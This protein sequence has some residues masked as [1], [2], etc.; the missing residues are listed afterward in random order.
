MR[1]LGCG[2]RGRPAATITHRG[3]IG[4]GTDVMSTI[5]PSLQSASS[6]AAF[7][8]TAAPALGLRKRV[9]D[10]V[11]GVPIDAT[12]WQDALNRIAS[13]AARQES[14]V[15]CLCNVHSVVTATQDRRHWNAISSA[16]LA[17][18]DG[19]PIA[20]ALRRLGH[21]RQ[22][23][24]SGPDLM[25]AVCE[26]AE[27]EGQA[28]YL[29]GGTPNTL[30]RLQERLLAMY[31]ELVIAGAVSPPFRALTTNEDGGVVQALNASGASILFVG[32]GCPKQEAWMHERRNRVRAVMLGVGASFDFHAGAIR[33]APVWMQNCGLEWLHRLSCDPRRLWKRYLVTNALFAILVMKMLLAGVPATKARGSRRLDP[34]D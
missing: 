22:T 9:K 29:Y 18:P 12:T 4:P 24:I 33:R 31:P 7:K 16:D 11:I 23:R 10:E 28:I 26:R 34:A 32:L 2:K 25:L 13:W 21:N 27:R 5:D 20:W 17:A 14:R 6:G 8:N 30:T 3:S 1:G 19:A 15:V